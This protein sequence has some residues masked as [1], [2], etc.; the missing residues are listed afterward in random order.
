MFGFLEPHLQPIDYRAAYSRCCQHQRVNHGLASLTFLSY[1]AVFA[2]LW[3]LDATGH[4][5]SLLPQQRCCR[6]RLPEP[7]S[8]VPDAEI[9]KFCGA[10][11]VLLASI[12][13]DDEIRDRRSLRARI[14]KR[15]LT[16]QER[17]SLAFFRS[18]DPE[19]AVRKKNFVAQHVAMETNG[20]PVT[21][22]SCT[23]LPRRKRSGTSS[24]RQR[25]CPT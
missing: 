11:G 7:L 18:L 13:L 15:I 6:L 10:L 9:Q 8:Q 17:E 5:A 16:K 21:L 2:Y 4:P 3:W 22:E 24:V 23:A 14:A 20:R 25:I 1:E 12:K 19:F